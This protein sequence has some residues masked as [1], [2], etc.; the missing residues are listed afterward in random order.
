MTLGQLKN[1]FF[2]NVPSSFILGDLYCFGTIGSPD[3]MTFGCEC[4]LLAKFVDFASVMRFRPQDVTKN[5]ENFLQNSEI[6]V[7]S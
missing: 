6:F 5:L 7:L 2:K 3:F 4:T 1:G